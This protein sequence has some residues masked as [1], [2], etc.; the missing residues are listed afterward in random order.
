MG[1]KHRDRGGEDTEGC[2][3]SREG[4]LRVQVVKDEVNQALEED[5]GKTPVS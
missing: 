1:P 3:A 5:L 2:G 4:R